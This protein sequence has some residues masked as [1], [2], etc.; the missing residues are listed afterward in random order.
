MAVEKGA[1]VL[2]EG[3]GEVR[4]AV[5]W[6]VMAVSKCSSAVSNRYG[7][8]DD[9]GIVFSS[10][11][12]SSMAAAWSFTFSSPPPFSFPSLGLGVQLVKTP[13]AVGWIGKG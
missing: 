6:R 2:T 9:W 3:G 11:G 10:G 13:V 7:K 4:V 12:G 1:K 5:P 8:E